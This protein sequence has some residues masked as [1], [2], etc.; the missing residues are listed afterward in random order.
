M[1]NETINVLEE[2]AICHAKGLT[3]AVDMYFDIIDRR[4]T[5]FSEKSCNFYYLP[6]AIQEEIDKSYEVDA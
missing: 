5:L 3:D 2:M 4:A 6:L 1:S